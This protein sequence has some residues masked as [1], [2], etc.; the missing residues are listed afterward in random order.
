MG[1]QTALAPPPNR[2]E[3]RQAWGFLPLWLILGTLS[4]QASGGLNLGT[5]VR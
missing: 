1:H 5:G 2:R 3:W 4:R